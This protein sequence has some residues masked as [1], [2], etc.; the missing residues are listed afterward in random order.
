MH[1]SEHFSNQGGGAF[2][3]QRVAFLTKGGPDFPGAYNIQQSAIYIGYGTRK[4][5]KICL[6]LRQFFMIITKN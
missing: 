4:L 1:T 6:M 2:A 3:P 5:V